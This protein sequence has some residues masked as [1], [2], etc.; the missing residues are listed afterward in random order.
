MDEHSLNA[1]F[2]I[3]LTEDG[4]VTVVNN[5]QHLKTDSSIEF[6]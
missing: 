2:P 6:I 4:I 5:E 1:K 3:D